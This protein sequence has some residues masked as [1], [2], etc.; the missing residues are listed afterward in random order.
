MVVTGGSSTATNVQDSLELNDLSATVKLLDVS[1][2]KGVVTANIGDALATTIGATNFT[3]GNTVV[4]VGA[5][6]I[7]ISDAS[8][9]V[10]AETVTSFVFTTDAANNA[11]GDPD[12]QWQISDF[13]GIN[14][15][16]SSV[17]NLT[18]LD[19]SGLG[20][21][22]FADILVA[23]VGGN[24]VITAN[25]TDN[26]EIVLVGEVAADLGIENFKFAV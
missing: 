16:G 6:G 14:E 23:D 1:G 9:A 22:G 18:V 3:T 13:A 17:S 7:D 19:L 8:H 4:K 15:V 21:T 10:G 2:Y 12:F 5:F 25:G 26:F 20:I 11:A 24:V